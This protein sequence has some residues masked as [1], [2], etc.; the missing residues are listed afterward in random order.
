MGYNKQRRHIMTCMSNDPF[1]DKSCQ[2][3]IIPFGS[4]FHLQNSE[5]GEYMYANDPKLHSKHRLA[6]T[7]KCEDES[8]PPCNE[9]YLWRVELS[10]LLKCTQQIMIN[11]NKKLFRRKPS[12][13]TAADLAT[14]EKVL[15]ARER[16]GEKKLWGNCKISEFW[17]RWW[18]GTEADT[19]AWTH[20]LGH[21]CLD[22]LAW[23]HLLGH[24]CLDTLAWTQTA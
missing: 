11:K 10:P 4:G 1:K 17:T 21:T 24:T 8:P 20:L 3:K 2:W 18:K 6:L 23:T 19:L 9:E 7:W 15:E 22:A 5:Y 12:R 13:P 14:L 16:I